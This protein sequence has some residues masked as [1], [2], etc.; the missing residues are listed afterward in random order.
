MYGEGEVFVSGGSRNCYEASQ[1]LAWR[2]E[3][4][5]PGHSALPR[6]TVGPPCS[7]AP[8]S[9]QVLE[10]STPCRPA[11]PWTPEAQGG[12]SEMRTEGSVFIQRWCKLLSQTRRRRAPGV[13]EAGEPNKS[14]AADLSC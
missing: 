11:D 9:G 13:G 12:E 10:A 14:M 4:G 1:F 6:E 3:L 8:S 5:V 7:L 2:R